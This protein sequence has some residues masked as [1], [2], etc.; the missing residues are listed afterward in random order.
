[1]T[2]S[3]THPPVSNAEKHKLGL[4]RLN[5]PTGERS[6]G[7]LFIQEMQSCGKVQIGEGHRDPDNNEMRDNNDRTF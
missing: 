2:Q 1:M 6:K 5:F 7:M 4:R 3:L